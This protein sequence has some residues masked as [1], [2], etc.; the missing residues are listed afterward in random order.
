M[1]LNFH[2]N[3]R[4]LVGMAFT[5]FVVLSII[6]AVVPAYQIQENN[7]PLPGSVAMSE[8]EELGMHVYV[9]EGCV[10]CHTQQVR[11]IDMDKP[12][13]GRPGI[14]ADYAW[15]TRMDVWRQPASVL[16][17]ERT[18]PDLTEIGERQPSTD[19]HYLHLFN[20]RSVVGQSIMPNYPWLFEVKE[21]LPEGEKALNVPEKYRNGIQGNIVP[22]QDAKN[23]IAYLLSLKQTDLPTGQD[24]AFIKYDFGKKKIAS[25]GGNGSEMPLPDGAAL[26]QQH[27]QACHQ[28]SGEGLKGAFPA[29]KGSLAVTDANPE[30]LVSIILKGYDAREEYGVMPAFGDRLS[31]G[32]IAAIAS[33]ERSS[34]GNGAAKVSAAEVKKIRDSLKPALP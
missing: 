15:K 26:Y 10:A 23:L 16:G 7:A 8:E 11:N 1:L 29:L 2:K 28:A 3:H 27:C 12:W 4:L 30:L 18:G 20:P 17:T 14:A 33:H 31:D 34:W 5:G 6:V 9:A 21:N 19:W 22:T 32:E 25:T 24:P 13:G